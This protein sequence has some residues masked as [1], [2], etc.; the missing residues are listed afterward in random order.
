MPEDLGEGLYLTG[1]GM[2]LVF[3][4]L[5]AFMLILLALR[6][7]FLDEEPAP[8]RQEVPRGQPEQEAIPATATE[9]S[10]APGP[11][12]AAA[13]PGPRVAAMAVALYLAM[14]QE[15]QPLGAEDP[16]RPQPAPSQHATS[17]SAQGRA[18]LMA[19]HGRR[20]PAYGQRPHTPYAPKGGA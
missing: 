18:S 3:L 11:Q 5:V 8:E 9:V 13:I 2:G 12:S 19:S 17:W 10:P 20:P 7:F 15:E 16:L 6:R 1:V 14:E 4:A